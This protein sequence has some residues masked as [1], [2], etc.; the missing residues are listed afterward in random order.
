MWDLAAVYE[1]C[2]IP[3]ELLTTSYPGHILYEDDFQI[4]AEPALGAAR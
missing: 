1:A 3:V 4:V 2:G